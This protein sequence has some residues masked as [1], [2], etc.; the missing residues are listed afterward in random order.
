MPGCTGAEGATAR[1]VSSTPWGDETIRVVTTARPPPW[2]APSSTPPVAGHGHR[3]RARPAGAARAPCAAVRRHGLIQ[4]VDVPAGTSLVHFTYR[5]H[6]VLEGFVI[7]AARLLVVLVGLRGVARCSASVVEALRARRDS[8]SVSGVDL[9]ARHPAPGRALGGGDGRRPPRGGPS[10][11]RTNFDPLGMA[12]AVPPMPMGTMVAPVRAARKAA[13]S[14]RSSTTGP[15]RRV[16]SGN[17]M[18]TSPRSS[19]SWARSR[20][21]RSAPSRWTGKAPTASR[22]VPEQRR[23]PHLVLGHVEDLAR[24]HLG[25]HEEVHEAAVHGGQDDR[26]RRRGR[27]RP[28]PPRRAS[29]RG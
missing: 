20:A 18:S 15:A 9:G 19:T 11:G 5:P 27:C 3:P 21:R 2:C 14:C 4:A 6:R 25:H 13:P 8:C 28:R 16:P 23:L 1:V 29:R 7:S 24:G 10:P 26:A 22:N 12:S 17:K